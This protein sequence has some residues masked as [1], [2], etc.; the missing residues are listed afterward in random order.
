MPGPTRVDSCH[1]RLL[2]IDASDIACRT[3]ADQEK[4]KHPAV[5]SV[6]LT[7]S[8]FASF[9]VRTGTKA[10]QPFDGQA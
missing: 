10:S 1:G 3:S 5:T 7:S 2:L 9:L 8:C 6:Y 4:S